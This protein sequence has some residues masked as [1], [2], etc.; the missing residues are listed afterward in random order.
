MPGYMTVIIV[1]IFLVLIANAIVVIIRAGRNRSPYGR[2]G[3][4]AP[5]EEDALIRREKIVYRRIAVEQDRIKRYL[6]LRD[7]TWALYEEVR[8]RHANDEASD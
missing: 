8:Q 2:R 3:K 6:E 5:K 7:K 1:L 4:K